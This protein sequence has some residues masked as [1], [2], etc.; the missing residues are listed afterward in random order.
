MTDEKDQTRFVSKKGTGIA[1]DFQDDLNALM[2]G[3]LA[4]QIEAFEANNTELAE[5]L[6]R[7]MKHPQRLSEKLDKMAA[8]DIK[9]LLRLMRQQK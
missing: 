8:G 5:R 4:L 9:G 7:L 2:E 3:L 6:A 1:S